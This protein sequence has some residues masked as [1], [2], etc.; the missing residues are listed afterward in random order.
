MDHSRLG[1]PAGRRLGLRSPL[2]AAPAHPGDLAAATL[3]SSSTIRSPST[4]ATSSRPWPGV[5]VLVQPVPVPALHRALRRA[6]EGRYRAWAAVVWPSAS[7]LT[8]SRACSPWAAAVLTAVELLPARCASATTAP[9]RR[10]RGAGG[11]LQVAHP[12]VGRLHRRASASCS[13][14]SGSV[15][16]GL[17]HAYSISMGYTNVEGWALYFRGLTRGPWCWP[18]WG[19]R[20]RR[21][22]GAASASLTLLGIASAVATASTRRA[23]STT[24]GCSALVPLGL[25]HGRLGLRH[26]L[27]RRGHVVAPPAAP[28][29]GRRHRAAPADRRCAAGRRAGWRDRGCVR[30]GRARTRFGGPAG[31]ARGAAARSSV[32]LRRRTGRPL[33]AGDPPP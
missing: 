6:A 10:G 25:P 14:A 12:V 1:H 3:P 26:G 27:C 18:G 8:S 4:G 22:C 31:W 24:C 23:A 11:P 32:D 33:H 7:S 21:R 13:P 28:A 2:P 15:P 5:R 17:E 29:L 20:R 30:R 16:F 9:R 19:D